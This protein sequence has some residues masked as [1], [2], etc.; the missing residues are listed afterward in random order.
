M[1]TLTFYLEIRI[2]LTV[3][4][5]KIPVVVVIFGS[6]ALRM[7]HASWLVVARVLINKIVS[8]V[9]RMRLQREEAARRSHAL[10]GISSRSGKRR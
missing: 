2:Y 10:V 3:L 8:T 9:A 1:V 4:E 5:V 6:S 7:L